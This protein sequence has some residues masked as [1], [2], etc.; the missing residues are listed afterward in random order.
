MV[1]KLKRLLRRYRRS[2]VRVELGSETG[3]EEEL[4]LPT[5]RLEERK[6]GKSF[7]IFGIKL[8]LRW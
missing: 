2:R 6:S 4:N 7:Q 5:W 3:I 1:G 8:T